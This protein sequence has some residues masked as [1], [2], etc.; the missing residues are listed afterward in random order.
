[1]IS[2]TFV[3]YEPVFPMLNDVAQTTNLI[4]KS[5]KI[6]SLLCLT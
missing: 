4:D 1:M 5:H 2:F 3:K 6:E